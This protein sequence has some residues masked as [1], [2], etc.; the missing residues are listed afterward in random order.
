M[1]ALQNMLKG[2]T[3]RDLELIARAHKMPFTRREPKAVGLAKL[4]KALQDG[5]YQKAF[6][7][8]TSAHIA[9][10][11]ALVAGGGWLPLPL[12]TAHFGEI[13]LYK[14]WRISSFNRFENQRENPR[15]PWRYPASVAERLY[16]LGYIVIRD[17][18]M[19]SIV[20]EVK[21][22][23]PPLPQ[24]EASTEISPITNDNRLALLRD[25]AA[26]LGVLLGVNAVPLHERWLSLSVM[27]EVNDCLQVSE[28]LD[29]HVCASCI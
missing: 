22:M 21:A 27:R 26:L 10:L 14:P 16:H 15:H 8:L 25:I 7:G 9:A 13:R 23:L 20:D 18:E 3:H 19:V 6:K 4:A 11:H 17:G 2:R 1:I 29:A 28:W 5:V 24:A 12:F